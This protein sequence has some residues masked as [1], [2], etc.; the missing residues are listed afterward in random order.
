MVT[1]DYSIPIYLATI[2]MIVKGWKLPSIFFR[3]YYLSV[4]HNLFFYF[5]YS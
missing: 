5:W 3:A 2:C 4:E 1:G